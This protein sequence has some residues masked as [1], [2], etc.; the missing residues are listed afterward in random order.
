VEAYRSEEEQVEALKSW[1]KENGRSTMIGVALALGLGF[2]WQ[3]WKKNEQVAADNASN[4]YQQMIQT[5]ASQED[6]DDGAARQ[7]AEELKDKYRGSTY[8]Q[9][10]ALHLARLDV[11]SGQ[12]AQA[13]AELRW[14]LSMASAG[15]DIHQL[16]QL[17]LARVLA[18]Q[19]QT[20][21]ALQMLQGATTDFVA[22]YAM[23]RGDIL[24]GQGNEAQALVAYESAAAA[25]DAG[26]PL[27]QTL[28]DKLQYLGAR[29]PGGAAEAG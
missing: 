22:S 25:L 8:A 24:L 3:A 9:F 6:L 16:A 10:A 7:I 2:G 12:P 20:D 27:P 14:V 11:N 1:W 21:E 19:G 18:S 23:A 29:Q 26:V 28:R 17:R 5:L 13:E 4:L 15:S